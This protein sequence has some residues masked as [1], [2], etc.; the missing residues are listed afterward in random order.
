MINK[1]Y[2]KR[3]NVLTLDETNIF[4]IEDEEFKIIP[5]TRTNKYSDAN[6]SS[7]IFYYIYNFLKTPHKLDFIKNIHDYTFPNSYN[8]EFEAGT[9]PDSIIY[10]TFGD[11]YNQKILLNSLPKKLICLKFGTK[12][13]QE[14]RSKILPMSLTHITFGDC[15]NHQ[16]KPGVL[17]PKLFSLTFGKSYN[18]ILVEKS[19]PDNLQIL[20]FGYDYN[21]S[22]LKN[23]LPKNLISLTFGYSFNSVIQSALPPHLTFLYYDHSYDKIIEKYI[24][25][26]NLKTLHFYGSKNNSNTI[27]TLPD[28]I[29]E[30]TIYHLEANITNLP[31]F[32]KKVKIM[33]NIYE[34][35]NWEFI[36]KIKVPFGCIITDKFNTEIN[37][38]T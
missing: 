9:L 17:P 37:M 18:Q 20:I 6:H 8:D 7:I 29:E 30:I 36:K 19:L 24:L 28:T 33:C 16:I 2:N 5:K 31:L 1:F 21:Q 25:P 22:I 13:N 14:I 11:H 27:N 26:R 35:N 32:F 3:T 4:Y 38:D 10:L 23:T 15:Y 34:N 12:Y